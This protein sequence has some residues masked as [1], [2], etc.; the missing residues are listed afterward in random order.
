MA[1]W[2]KPVARVLRPKMGAPSGSD[3]KRGPDK[4]GKR[5][6]GTAY[7]ADMEKWG[8]RVRRDIILLEH[9][10]K[11]LNQTTGANLDIVLYDDPGDPP[12]PPNSF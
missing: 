9:Y 5:A 4:P 3:V 7:A 12:P 8:R 2:K 11:Q 10:L 1:K 6:R